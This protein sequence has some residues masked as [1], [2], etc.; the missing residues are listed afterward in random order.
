MAA[1]PPMATAT[2]TLRRVLLIVLS[3]LEVCS[4]N[5]IDGNCVFWALIG[6]LGAADLTAHP[7]LLLGRY[8]VSLPIIV[9][10]NGYTP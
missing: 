3:V 5:V 7:I 10:L 6:V 8:I 1:P 4:L 2:G 9:W